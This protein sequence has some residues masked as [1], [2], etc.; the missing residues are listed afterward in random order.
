M[1]I[2]E[3]MMTG[4][5]K[6]DKSFKNDMKQSFASEYFVSNQS[7][8]KDIFGNSRRPKHRFEDLAPDVFVQTLENVDKGG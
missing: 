7:F 3:R 8:W 4:I 2:R 5:K 1:P 6:I